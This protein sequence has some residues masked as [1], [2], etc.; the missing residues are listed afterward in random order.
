MIILVLAV[1]SWNNFMPRW[2]CFIKSLP[3]NFFVEHHGNQCNVIISTNRT[4]H[5][6]GDASE[7]TLSANRISPLNIQPLIKRW[8]GTESRQY[9]DIAQLNPKW[10]KSFFFI[11]IR[12]SS[13]TR[14]ET[15]F[16]SSYYDIK[17]FHHPYNWLQ[18]CLLL[19]AKIK[20]K[21]QK[22]KKKVLATVLHSKAA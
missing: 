6:S 8:L 10:F 12:M 13:G 16:I 3:E 1:E 11:L 17:L 9:L 21:Q 19:V 20:K 22:N 4:C 7:R 15:F 18:D 5:T 2:R 14:K